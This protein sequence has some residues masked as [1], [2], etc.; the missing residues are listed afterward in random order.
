M[1]N[2]NTVAFSIYVPLQT[3]SSIPSI[4]QETREELTYLKP[5]AQD[6]EVLSL[7]KDRGEDSP[8]NLQDSS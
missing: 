5:Q 8:T 7:S 4:P 2:L 6:L 1:Q 3:R